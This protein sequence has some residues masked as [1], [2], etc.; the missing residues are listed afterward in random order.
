[1]VE[2]HCAL[3]GKREQSKKAHQMEGVLPAEATSDGAGLS[4]IECSHLQISF[5]KVP[6]ELRGAIS[7][8]SQIG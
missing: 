4:V 7:S 2:K 6:S 1:M 5:S 3:D 8:L